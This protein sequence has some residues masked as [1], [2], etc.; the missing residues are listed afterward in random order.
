MNDSWQRFNVIAPDDSDGSNAI[1]E[2]KNAIEVMPKE[3]QE[4]VTVVSP[5]RHHF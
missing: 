1:E 3:F 2:V 4:Y 5:P